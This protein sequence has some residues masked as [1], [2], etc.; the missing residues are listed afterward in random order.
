LLDLLQTFNLHHSLLVLARYHHHL[1]H[2]LLE[3]FESVLEDELFVLE[4]DDC[5]NDAAAVLGSG[6]GG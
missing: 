1:D 6:A 5:L 3:E 4:L 2:R